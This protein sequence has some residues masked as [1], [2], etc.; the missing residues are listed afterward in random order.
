MWNLGQAVNT[1]ILLPDL[2]FSL[3]L[4]SDP[5]PDLSE[6]CHARPRPVTTRTSRTMSSILPYLFIEHRQGVSVVV[7]VVD[8]AAAVLVSCFC[9]SS[10]LLQY[11][12]CIVLLRA[13]I[14]NRT[15][16]T[17][18]NLHIPLF[19]PILFGPIYYGPS[20]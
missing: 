1:T 19:L 14:L 3:A 13:T 12:V 7:A 15:Y 5:G 10:I 17:H 18:K 9:N 4:T 8:I 2:P 11:Y 20:Q 6:C 16:G